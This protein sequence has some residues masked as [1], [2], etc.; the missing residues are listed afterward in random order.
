MKTNRK[1]HV[2]TQQDFM[3]PST[4]Y[5]CQLHVWHS[6]FNKRSRQNWGKQTS[7]KP[8][9]FPL[10]SITR[11]WLFTQWNG[12]WCANACIVLCE[13]FVK[14]IELLRF[15]G[16]SIRP[17]SESP[18]YILFLCKMTGHARNFFVSFVN[19]LNRRKKTNKQTISV[20]LFENDDG[21]NFAHSQFQDALYEWKFCCFFFQMKTFFF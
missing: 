8:L 12:K 4:Y 7:W 10:N 18:L 17:F 19:Y 11:L 3:Y 9:V 15:H 20:S 6:T 5:R 14:R 2:W 1:K 16:K 21:V 13:Q